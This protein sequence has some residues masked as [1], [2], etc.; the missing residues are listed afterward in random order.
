MKNTFRAAH[1][2]DVFA[3]QAA[4]GLSKKAFCARHAIN[5]ATFYYW[6]RRL[7]ALDRDDE[8]AGFQQLL[9]QAEHELS[10]R[11][12]TGEVVIRSRSLAALGQ[13]LQA[14]ADA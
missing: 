8:Q 9:P 13:V 10:L 14:L 3:K 12:S 1:W 11:I 4:S 6:Q 7:Q 2:S 5:P